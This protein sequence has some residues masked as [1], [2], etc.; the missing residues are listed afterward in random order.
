MHSTQVGILNKLLFSLELRYT[1]LKI[2][3]NIENNTFKFHLDKV[4]KEGYVKKNKN[5]LY[6][7]TMKG[8][9]LATHI[10]TDTN[11]LVKLRKIS[12]HLYCE[13]ELKGKREVLIYTRL[14]QPFYG[15]Q[16]FP[17]GKVKFGEKFEDAAKREFLEETGLIGNPVLFN[18]THYLVKEKSTQELLDDKLFLDFWIKEPTGKL[19]GNREGNFEWIEFDK[20]TTYLTNP[21]DTVDVYIKAFDLIDNHSENIHFDELEHVTS[22]F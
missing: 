7:L 3:S 13:R 12:V 11:S 14:K 4:I 17:A 2:D 18:I 8:K 6:E 9:K 1:D 5:G 16:G 15:K 21:F 22:D 19:I 20:I 10:D